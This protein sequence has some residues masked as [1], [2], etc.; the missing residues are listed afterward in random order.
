MTNAPVTVNV[1]GIDV[2]YITSAEVNSELWWQKC[3][4]GLLRFRRKGKWKNKE[5]ETKLLHSL[6]HFILKATKN[7]E[8]FSNDGMKGIFQLISFNWL[9]LSFL[10]KTRRKERLTAVL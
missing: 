3:T 9:F 10:G 8:Y 1:I 5:Y 4:I 7:G 2:M 6:I